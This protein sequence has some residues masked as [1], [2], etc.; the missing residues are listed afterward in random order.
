MSVLE[1]LLSVSPF[2]FPKRVN[3]KLS[4]LGINPLDFL[5]GLFTTNQP[6]LVDNGGGFLPPE[7]SGG[8]CVGVT[9]RFYWVIR[10]K[11]DGA[12]FP[13]AQVGGG[14]GAI[15][16]LSPITMSDGV[17]LG[18]R[19]VNP[20]FP[21]GVEG[22]LGYTAASA[23]VASFRVE[24]QDGLPDTCGDPLPAPDPSKP[25]DINI[26]LPV[27]LP[28]PIPPTAPVPLPRVPLPPWL[29]IPLPPTGLPNPTDPTGNDPLSK[30]DGKKLEEKLD[31]L[32]ENLDRLAED[33]QCIRDKV[34]AT[35]GR[36]YLPMGTFTEAGAIVVPM[37][38]FGR[39]VG[40]NLWVQNEG[41]VTTKLFAY[42]K[43]YKKYW[44]GFGDVGFI[45]ETNHPEE[46]SRIIYRLQR[47]VP[48]A[49]EPK[50]FHFRFEL[51]V[52]VN[53]TAVVELVS[54]TANG[55]V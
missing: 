27:N 40:L 25:P 5:R 36:V 29:P 3:D 17:S 46:P 31:K 18:Y 43:Y 55:E 14:A 15:A 23:E 24:R 38:A 51:G 16:S 11:S 35:T 34:C 1:N 9:Y 48:N 42:G 45:S 32:N 33:I 28:V 13:E 10:R 37:P 26:F 53:I 21:S 47:V 54:G 41:S 49:F 8:Q 19:L 50:G 6:S 20:T 4:E 30:G 7:F 39:L 12:L 22:S 44:L 2:G 52:Y